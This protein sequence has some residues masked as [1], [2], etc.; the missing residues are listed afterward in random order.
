MDGNK[1]IIQEVI[2]DNDLIEVGGREING[3]AYIS[4]FNF[5]GEDQKKKVSELSGGERNRVHL[6][7]MLKEGGNVLFSM[8][9]PTIWM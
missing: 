7:K 3:R 4:K 1:T 8:S 9:P 5:S 6:A 2:G